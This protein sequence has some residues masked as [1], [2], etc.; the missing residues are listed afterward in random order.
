MAVTDDPSSEH[1]DQN[2]H[3]WMP[4]GMRSLNVQKVLPDHMVGTSI[5]NHPRDIAESNDKAEA[6]FDTSAEAYVFV[7][8]NG[9]RW[10][11]EEIEVRHKKNGERSK[12]EQ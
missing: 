4:K 5:P 10:L 2:L 9:K 8:K 7:D 3:H 6:M 12:L 1:L 11:H